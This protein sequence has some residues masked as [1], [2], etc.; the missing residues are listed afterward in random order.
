MAAVIP[1]AERLMLFVHEAPQSG[2]FLRSVT[3]DAV[4][5]NKFAAVATRNF[6][7]MWA[8]RLSDEARKAVNAAFDATSSWR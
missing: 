1:S 8:P 4:M 2:S 7:P 6:N 3:G 5:Q